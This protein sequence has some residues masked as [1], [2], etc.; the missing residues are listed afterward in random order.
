MG[1]PVMVGVDDAPGSPLGNPDFTTDHF[2]VIV[3]SGT[4]ANGNYFQFYDN[5]SKYPVGG[6]NPYNRLYYDPSTGKISGASSSGYA[7][8]P[9]RYNYIITQIRKNK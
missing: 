7:H 1:L 8:Q 3:G 2:V 5:A 6:A 9:G 4:D